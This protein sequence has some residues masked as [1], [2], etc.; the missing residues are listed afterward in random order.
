M[1][2][3]REYIT[4]STGGLCNVVVA[5]TV[6]CTAEPCFIIVVGVTGRVS[7]DAPGACKEILLF[8][9]LFSLCPN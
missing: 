6:V 2:Q 8:T 9:F 3:R 7:S 1:F 4:C 5:V